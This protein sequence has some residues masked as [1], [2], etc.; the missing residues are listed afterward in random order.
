MTTTT[1]T[2]LFPLQAVLF[3]GGLLRLKVFEARYL[4]L[5]AEC[6]RE[7]RPFGVV[8]L[9][10]GSDTSRRNVEFET[11]GTMAELIDVDSER[12]NIL[13]VRCRGMQRFSLAAPTQRDD[14]LWLA[15]TTSWPDDEALAPTPALLPTVRGLATAIA[16]L[17]NSG[18]G[19][20]FLEP[21]RFDD[22]A[23]VANRWCE[24]LPIPQLAKQKLM[25]LTDPLMRLQLVDDFLRS[26][27]VVK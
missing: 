19:A 17:N 9:K 15:E 23:W 22:A 16:A 20:P 12:P 5:V 4:D 24:I 13:Q 25:E 7:Q 3:P 27:G 2:S 14:G 1:T 18:N 6:L 26:K 21:Y 10:S 8:A 11:I